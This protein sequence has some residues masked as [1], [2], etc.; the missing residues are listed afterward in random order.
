MLFTPPKRNNYFLTVLQ[1]TSSHF[2]LNQRFVFLK[3]QRLLPLSS[4]DFIV[5]AC[6]THIVITVKLPIS[7]PTP[8]QSAGFLLHV[9]P[10]FASVLCEVLIL[11]LT[12]NAI[13]KHEANNCLPLKTTKLYFES[14]YNLQLW[15]CKRSQPKRIQIT[16][17]VFISEE[18]FRTENITIPS[19]HP[20]FYWVERYP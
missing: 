9:K 3:I 1:R 16:S 5:F 17:N 12:I 2:V 18:L 15:W 4:Y 14:R 10:Y 8:H 7:P 6:S 13:S 11:L 20:K 19:C